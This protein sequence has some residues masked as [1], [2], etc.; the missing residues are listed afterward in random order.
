MPISL[1]HGW[2]SLTPVIAACALSLNSM[3]GAAQ[4]PRS[5]EMA[6]PPPMRV[7]S[8]DE[9]S[10]LSA[11]KDPKARVRTSID[12]ATDRLTKVEDF[13]SQKEFDKAS[14]ELGGYLGLIDDLRAFCREMNRDKGSTRDLY[15]HLEIALRAH[16]PRL[17]VVRR[18]TPVAYAVHIKAAEEYVRDTRSEALDSF[19]GHSVLREDSNGGEKKPESTK[20]PPEGVKRP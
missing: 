3:N 9:R 14:E 12:L 11:A 1:H 8:R 19:Y 16:I 4:Q 6:A 13:T 10:Q 7:V 17:A 18:S 15:R 2:I 20:Q 5:P